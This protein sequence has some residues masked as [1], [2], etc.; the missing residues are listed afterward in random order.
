MF[1]LLSFA[2]RCYFSDEN[3]I[4]D[5]RE[6]IDENTIVM[7]ADGE[8]G[9][10]DKKKKKRNRKKGAGKTQGLAGDGVP[11]TS[12]QIPIVDQ[13]RDGVFPIGEIQHYS[14]SKDDRT[15]K[16]RFI[17]EEKRALDRMHNDIYNE[18]R[19]AAEAHRQVC[20][21]K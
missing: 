21:F 17:N 10:G 8:E 1:T 9:E 11:P 18:V 15:A 14:S 5:S 16:D 20:N 4:P 2:A 13:F 19:L 12:P 7:E 6:P 3:N